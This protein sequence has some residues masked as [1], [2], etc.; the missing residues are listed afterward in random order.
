MSDALT[1]TD[2][3]VNGNIMGATSAALTNAS[4]GGIQVS[5]A[6]T[7]DHSTTGAITGT[8]TN[9]TITNGSSIGSGFTMSDALT[10]TDSTVNGNIMGATSADLTNASTGNIQVNG[11]LTADNSTTG[12]ITGTVADATITNGSSI[13]SGFT[14]SGELTMSDSTVAGAV[15]GATDAELTQNSRIE[16]N[17]DMSGELTV[18]DST[19]TGA[20]TGA[21]SADLTNASTGNVTLT[22]GA[23]TADHSTLGAISG[24]SSV[25]L[26][27][28]STVTGDVA[29]N[30]K[31]TM[32]GS[33]VAGSVSGATDAVLTQSSRI[34]GN[35]GM[36]GELTIT[37]GSTITG[38]V[39]GASKLTVEDAA[40]VGGVN[41][42]FDEVVIDGSAS[43]AVTAT[44]GSVTVKNGAS[45][46]GSITTTAVTAGK[47]HDISVLTGST[48]TGDVT[49]AGDALVSGSNTTVSGTVSGA[50]VILADHA[51]AGSVST[52]G[53]AIITDA[54]VT[55][56][57]TADTLAADGAILKD[58]T[59]TNANLSDN[60]QVR[61]TLT[62]DGGALTA[63]HATVNAITGTVSTAD[64]ST[65]ELSGNL[66][67]TGDVTMTH[68][69]L[70][71][72]LSSTGDKVTLTQGASVTEV[73][74]AGTV[75][76]TDSTVD[77]LTADTLVAQN[78]QLGTVKA[79]HSTITGG[80]IS[81]DL[82]GRPAHTRDASLTGEATVDGTPIA[83]NVE[84]NKLTISD[85]SVGG[86]IHTNELTAKSGANTAK[87]VTTGS[88]TVN[89][90]A[91]LTATTGNI[92]T[93]GKLAVAGTLE[94]QN[95]SVSLSSTDE[96]SAVSGTVKAAQD[97]TTN[98]TLALNGAELT[99]GQKVTLGGTVS[100]TETTLAA[101]G[102]AVNG[103][104][105]AGA[106]TTL[107]G[108]VS[109]AG[110]IEKSGGDALVLA[111]G[112][113]V[114]SLAVSDGSTLDIA[115]DAKGSLRVNTASFS[116][117][118]TL[119]V[120]SDLTA[121][122][123]D[124]L[125]AG[126][127]NGGGATVKLDSVGNI[128]EAAVADQTRLT[129]I[130]GAVLTSFN[131]DVEHSLD[132]L[133]AHMDG[134]DV[135]LSKNY[136]GASKNHNQSQTA[137]ALSSINTASVAGTQ[138][139]AVLDALAHTRSEADALKALDTLSG[140]GLAG[141]QKIVADE[142]HEHVQTMRS[143][144][145]AAN[146]GL[147]HRFTPDGSIIP[148]L[149]SNAVTASMTAGHSDVSD[150]GN[151]GKYTR[152]ST[153][154]M[155]AL[156]HAINSHWSFGAD[157]A[158]SRGDADCAETSFTSDTIF[159]DVA[160]MY[161]NLR[162][163][164]MASLGVAFVNMDTERTL[165][166]RA[167]GHDYAGKAEGST[168]GTAVTFSYEA[169]YDLIASEETTTGTRSG[170]SKHLLSSVVQADAVYASIDDLTEN[171]AGN[172][173]LKAE[174]DDVAA[175]TAGVGARYTYNFGEETNPGY[176][177]FEVMGVVNAGDS[178]PKVNNS[179]IGGSP[180]FAVEGPE[181][182]NAGLRLNAS[183]L[184]P[185]SDEWAVFG[186]VTS[187]FR[188][189]QTFVGGSVGLK[190]EF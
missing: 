172:A 106:G 140:R 119:R 183:A 126:T 105:K 124:V 49:A 83:G 133:N 41:G 87:E 92:T 176:L 14:M 37:G 171:G 20:I 187:E 81:G 154:A 64:L 103:T 188:A 9:A 113:S 5:G 6:L 153:G 1:V 80:S 190:C 148:G 28:G 189:D 34:E 2:S 73:N 12:A 98:G 35:L 146:A 129:V 121:G 66:A 145:A 10:V 38:T 11:A 138:L 45:V 46:N 97:I 63:N 30:G 70:N 162:F 163:A 155:V 117:D 57:L 27:N 82:T 53:T 111:D 166:V 116:N 68:A 39:T 95:G 8:V 130:N 67:A 52:D 88:L 136:K 26:T 164:Q 165:G 96:A 142:T 161:R 122:G 65:S 16:G 152:N 55:E 170:R 182:G 134:G 184:A 181:S 144:L 114:G 7:A 135:V 185:I 107:N 78:A 23:L 58:A 123:T 22:N 175:L 137:D 139:G 44:D 61:G 157:V 141:A 102:I 109:G 43:G 128:R 51:Q 104:L 36:N 71:G 77:T 47:N 110:R 79:D 127:V 4:T 50:N 25:D 158:Y 169:T 173:G 143:T 15:S 168:T 115:G 147:K 89:D 19:V 75:K 179:F 56:S 84:L 17:L 29:M 90:G 101:N 94:S 120:S 174:F 21:T 76:V 99:A 132:T 149:S 54:T 125:Q 93:N 91:S 60:T 62:M 177:N 74:A 72:T 33:T 167:A 100:A 59:V 31:L 159:A 69:T 131:A 118:A 40:S 150:N 24:A 18:T 48:V 85:V 112:S 151:S 178:T 160:M 156:A 42:N 3:T 186:T 180:M 108:T 86:H 13:G 32:S